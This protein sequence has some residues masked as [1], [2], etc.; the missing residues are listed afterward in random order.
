[1]AE[2]RGCGREARC[3]PREPLSPGSLKASLSLTQADGR[4]SFERAVEEKL[5]FGYAFLSNFGCSSD[6]N[7]I[8]RSS[9]SL[10]PGS[11]LFQE[12]RFSEQL[13]VNVAPTFPHPSGHHSNRLC[14]ELLGRGLPGWLR[15][16]GGDS[17]D[18]APSSQLP[19]P[20]RA[21]SSA[22]V[23]LAHL[24]CNSRIL[25]L[26]NYCF[27]SL[28]ATQPQ[29][30]IHQTF[31]EHPVCVRLRGCRDHLSRSS[32][33]C[34]RRST[35]CPLQPSRSRGLPSLAIACVSPPGVLFW[36][37]QSWELGRP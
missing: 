18:C 12:H 22:A 17:R 14:P 9:Q 28:P 34:C 13:L 16:R 23:I 30:L 26:I 27:P 10:S 37:I 19:L 2:P 4:L 35:P 6:S 24:A 7:L 1:M 29:S 3:P 15:G 33:A 5:T 21:G 32:K 31:I 8:P 25:L 36:K 20:A 11:S